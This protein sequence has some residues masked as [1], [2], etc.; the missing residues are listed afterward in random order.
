MRFQYSITSPKQDQDDA[1][2]RVPV[3]LHLSNRQIQ[4]IAL[5]DSGA[6]INVLPF[7]LGQQLGAVWDDA[8]ALLPLGGILGSDGISLNIETQVGD[9]PPVE[10]SFAW[11]QNDRVPLILGQ[12]DFFENFR[13]CFERYN[14]E[15]EITPK[16]KA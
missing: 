14:L 7:E 15:F 8:K 13:V 10:L 16:P 4:A 12:Y 5:V 6:T 1:M 2:P 11:V 9:Y 3:T